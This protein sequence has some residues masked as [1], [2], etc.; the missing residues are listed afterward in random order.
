M[1]QQLV[2]RGVDAR[3]V[4][5][6]DGSQRRAMAEQAAGLPVTMAGFVSD[7]YPLA[8][9][10]ASADVVVVPGQ[11]DTFGLA[12]LEAM[13]CGAPVVASSSGALPELAPAG[14]GYVVAPD[15]ALM[16]DAVIDCSPMVRRRRAARHRAEDFSWTATVETCWPCTGCRGLPAPRGWLWRLGG[17][18]V[19]DEMA[20]APR[21]RSRLDCP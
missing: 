1:I 14:A 5:C 11:Y 15:P 17:A 4:G 7:R 19:A 16:A 21:S 2:A 20:T 6:G 12:A 8:A 18:Q 3:L 10:L 13:A 9:I